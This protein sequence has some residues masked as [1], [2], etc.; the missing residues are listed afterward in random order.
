VANREQ[1]PDLD[2][3]F[4]AFVDKATGGKKNAL[5]TESGGPLG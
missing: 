4:R 5:A 2:R 3:I 1:A